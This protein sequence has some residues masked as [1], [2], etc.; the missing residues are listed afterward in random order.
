MLNK[1]RAWLSSDSPITLGSQHVG[2]VVA[3]VFM[4][5][6]ACFIVGYFWGKR[7]GAQEWC[8]VITRD[9]FADQ[10]YNSLCSAALADDTQEN[11]NSDNEEAGSESPDSDGEQ[12]D[13][14]ESDD[15]GG[16]NMKAQYYAQLAGFSSLRRA[17]AFVVRLNKRKIPVL[18]KERVSKSSKG[19]PVRWYQVVTE[20]YEDQ[21][22]LNSVVAIL[23][24]EEKLRDVRIAQS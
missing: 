13:E 9:A 6:A 23:K 17:E 24:K 12:E 15:A 8:T 19:R 14:N 2:W 5:N 3:A 1:I 16:I 10:I 11:V 7:A 4:V 22:A 21:D 18:I 20:P